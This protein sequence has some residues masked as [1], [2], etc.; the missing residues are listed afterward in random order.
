M[1][2]FTGVFSY[3]QR[4]SIVIKPTNNFAKEGEICRKPGIKPKKCE[5]GFICKTR[6]KDIL[7]EI[8]GVS[9][10]CQRK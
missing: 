4:P 3:C 5:P 9:S 6:N 10:I 1:G 7:S 8:K 2:V